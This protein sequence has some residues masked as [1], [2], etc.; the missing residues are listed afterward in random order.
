MAAGAAG[1]LDATDAGRNLSKDRAWDLTDC[2]DRTLA[3]L[4][5]CWAVRPP[6]VAGRARARG[7]CLP[8][9]GTSAT[10]LRTTLPRVR[11]HSSVR[12]IAGSVLRQPRLWGGYVRRFGRPRRLICVPRSRRYGIGKGRSGAER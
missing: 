8:S 6:G 1:V 7:S 5:A 2:D 3:E 10:L 11:R 9:T 4:A 12:A